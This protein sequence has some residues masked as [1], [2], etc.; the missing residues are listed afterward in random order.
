V[1]LVYLRQDRIS[2]ES[3]WQSKGLLVSQRSLSYVF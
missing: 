1:D 2:R 3:L